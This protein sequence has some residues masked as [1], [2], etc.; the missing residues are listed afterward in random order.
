MPVFISNI[1]TTLKNLNK[2]SSFK[3][4]EASVDKS[5]R[6][7]LLLNLSKVGTYIDTD[8]DQ[9]IKS[10][11]LE[12]DDPRA[13]NFS[14]GIAIYDKNYSRQQITNAEDYI[15][16]DQD[17]TESSFINFEATSSTP[18]AGSACSGMTGSFFTE[19]NETLLHSE[20]CD[21]LG[22]ETEGGYL[23]TFVFSGSLEDMTRVFQQAADR[24]VGWR[25]NSIRDIVSKFSI[26]A[27]EEDNESV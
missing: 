1:R 16:N 18:S 22:K 21:F 17:T 25:E 4:I 10:L 6:E 9:N 27:E 12:V 24:G 19:T 5:I 2:R 15:F 7:W 20:I 23:D 8:S 11:T 14:E 3:S 26:Y 13:L